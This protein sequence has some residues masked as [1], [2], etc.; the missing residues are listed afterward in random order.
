M[1]RGGS[2]NMLG[3]GG[4]RSNLG[5]GALRGGERGVRVGGGQDPAAAKRELLRKLQER[6]EQHEQEHEQ[7]GGQE[8]R[9]QQEGT[10]A[11]GRGEGARG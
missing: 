10:D 6:H 3:V 1:S 7:H 8:R 4:T 5:R 11:E 9:A 2:G